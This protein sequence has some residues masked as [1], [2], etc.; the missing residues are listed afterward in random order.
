[1]DA[2]VEMMR[3]I[4][5]ITPLQRPQAL[6]ATAKIEKKQSYQ[7]TPSRLEEY[8][9]DNV[10]S[11]GLHENR[12]TAT[13]PLVTDANSPIS[14]EMS[15]YMDDLEVYNQL[16]KSFTPIAYDL[17]TKLERDNSNIEQVCEVTKI[18]PNGLDGV[19]KQG[20]SSS[21]HVGGME[22]LLPT[23]R[24][25]KICNELPRPVSLVVLRKHFFA[26]TYIVHT[27][28]IQRDLHSS[29]SSF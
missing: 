4:N 26:I 21:T 3:S 23:M 13:C 2:I 19:F 1:M 17:R 16:M 22:P 27:F 24:S 20:I 5:D 29:K 25:H 6:R 18:H 15:T 10:E 9:I 14:K 12:A 28:H 11:L 8:F 7:Y